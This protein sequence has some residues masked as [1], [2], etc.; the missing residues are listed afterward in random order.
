[1]RTPI[2]QST[3]RKKVYRVVSKIKRGEVL[4]YA[5][6]AKRAGYPGAARAVGTALSHNVCQDVPCHRVVRG[7][8][9]LGGYAYGLPVKRAILDREA[10]TGATRR[11][12]AKR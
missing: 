7:T 8:G 12:R 3:F 4:T 5:E 1:M 9:N 2:A 10:S 11:P 6:V